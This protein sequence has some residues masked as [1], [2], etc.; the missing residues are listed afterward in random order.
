MAESTAAR[1]LAQTGFQASG[2]RFASTI[3]ELLDE[4]LEKLPLKDAF[5]CVHQ[6]TRWTYD[7]LVMYSDAYASGLHEG[8]CMLPF[9]SSSEDAYFFA[10]LTVGMAPIHCHFRHMS[11]PHLV[12]F[13]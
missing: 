9:S 11:C 3:P 2:G 10:T 12:S 5:R 4:S 1:A 6:K 7:E 13:P 8:T